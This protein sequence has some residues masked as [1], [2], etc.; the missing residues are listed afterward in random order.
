MKYQGGNEL[1][2][3]M[4]QKNISIPDK[5]IAV[6][7]DGAHSFSFYRNHN[8]LMVDPDTLTKVLPSLEGKYFLIA[9]W[10]KRQLVDSGYLVEPIV[11]TLDYNVATVQLKFLNPATRIKNCDTIM[12]AKIYKP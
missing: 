5:Q 11:Q 3:L 7:E 4:Q 9:N 12:L 1:V 10:K 6:V 2:K 8:H